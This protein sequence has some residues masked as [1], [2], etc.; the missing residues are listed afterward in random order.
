MNFR[1]VD[2]IIQDLREWN[3]RNP[4]EI[5]SSFAMLFLSLFIR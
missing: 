3:R 4:E 5:V 2:P 1:E